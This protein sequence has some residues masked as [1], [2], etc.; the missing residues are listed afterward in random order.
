MREIDENDS[1]WAELVVVCADNFEDSEEIKGDSTDI[2]QYIGLPE[3]VPLIRFSQLLMNAVV[4]K[5]K[6]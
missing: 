2:K 5:G 1:S 6:S 4:E 3:E